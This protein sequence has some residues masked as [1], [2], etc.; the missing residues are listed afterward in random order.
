MNENSEQNSSCKITNQLQFKYGDI[1]CKL[2]QNIDSEVKDTIS[3][4]T[5]VEPNDI[6][7]NGLNLNYD[8]VSQ[9]V[10]QVREQGVITSAYI[11]LRSTGVANDKYLTYL[12]K[13]MDSR[14]LFHGMG[15]GVRLTLSY[16][17]LKN[18]F[19][20]FP[21]IEEQDAMVEY[22][23]KAT[24]KIDEAIAQQQKMID[25]LNERKQIIIQK[26]VTKGLD[27]NTPM[28]DS[29]IEWIGD[30]PDHWDM[31]KLNY[32]IR[33]QNGCPFDSNK[34]SIDTG[35]PLI[36]IRDITSGR[37]ETFYNGKYDLDYV[38]TRGDLL[39]GMD[40]DFTV[41]LWNSCDAL[42]NQRCCRI[43]ND[44]NIIDKHYLY[45]YLPLSL[46]II[47]DLTPATTVKHLSDKDIRDIL[48]P[49]PDISIQKSIANHLDIEVGKIDNAMKTIEGIITRL[50]ERKNI[51]INDVVTGKVK[52]S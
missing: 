22:L 18:R 39:V 36:R 20:P 4:Y 6:M 44:E 32:I 42:L 49:L 43:F 46:K 1:V 37:A 48:I 47:N 10:A 19:L 50:Q 25:L 51:I 3:K 27:P 40:G 52:I 34:F 21:P 23:D 33:V 29:G 11:S 5:I 12:L 17:E 31:M 9:R 7:I 41:R 8:F 14:K 35:F 30:I 24:A 15:T 13:A 26:A 38:V 28:K 16:K 45:Y 2:N